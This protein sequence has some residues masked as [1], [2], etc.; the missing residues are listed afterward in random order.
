MANA[1]YQEGKLYIN[2]EAVTITTVPSE[3]HC[4]KRK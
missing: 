2:R 1:I 3:T 4:L